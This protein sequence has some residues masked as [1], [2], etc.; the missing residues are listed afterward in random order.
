[1]NKLLRS[2]PIVI[3]YDGSPASECALLEAA[4]LLAPHRALVVV[5]WEPD[6]PFEILGAPT[7][8]PAPIDIRTALAV[9]EKLYEAAQRLAEHGANLARKAGLDA[10]GLAVADDVTPAATLVRVVQERHA[11]ALV[12]GS[13]GHTGMTQM[14]MGSTSQ[15]LVNRAPCPVVVRGPAGT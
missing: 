12:V 3:G 15:E 2:G 11:P 7:F 6:V 5:V 10:Q 1:M 14:L 4:E 13:R 8:E 9:D